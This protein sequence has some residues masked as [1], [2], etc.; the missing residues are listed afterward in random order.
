MENQK[1]RERKQL[2]IGKHKMVLAEEKRQFHN[3]LYSLLYVFNFTLT[4]TTRNYYFNFF[5]E[6]Y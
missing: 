1:D 6:W 4:K 3:E 5:K 2:F